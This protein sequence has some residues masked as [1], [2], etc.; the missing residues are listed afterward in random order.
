MLFCISEEET[1]VRRPCPALCP[2]I[3]FLSLA[4]CSK[5]G[6]GRGMK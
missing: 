2:T 3:P 4:L 1:A 6:W 5:M